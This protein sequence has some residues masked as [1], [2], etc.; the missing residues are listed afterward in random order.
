MMPPAGDNSTSCETCAVIRFL[1][2]KN[3]SAVEIHLELYA[4]Y[5]KNAM[6]EETVRQW[7]R[8]FKDGLSDLPSVVSDELAQTVDQKIS[9][10]Q[11]FIMS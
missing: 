3:M 10:K 2:T 1:C 9:E 6:S 8:M 11:C 5:G 4:V 7:C